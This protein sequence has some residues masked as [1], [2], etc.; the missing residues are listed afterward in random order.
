MA[1]SMCQC[2]RSHVDSC[3]GVLQWSGILLTDLQWSMKHVH[4]P[5]MFI[6]RLLITKLILLISHRSKLLAGSTNLIVV[7][8]LKDSG[9]HI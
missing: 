2:A 6:I 4:H 7:Q 3:G 1:V 5:S 9:P 8:K